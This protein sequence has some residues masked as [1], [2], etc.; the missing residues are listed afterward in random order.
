[1]IHIVVATRGRAGLL[2]RTLG[3]LAKC[4]PVSVFGETLVIENGDR[5]GAEDVVRR[6][7]APL[8]A[9]YLFHP[10][11]VSIVSGDMTGPATGPR[12]RAQAA[13]ST[14]WGSRTNFLAAPLS[15][16]R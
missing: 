15:K 4:E 2:A 1:M 5:S 6:A 12:L 7:A 13:G 16:S 9:R 10:A 3:S 8:H 14:P 11:D